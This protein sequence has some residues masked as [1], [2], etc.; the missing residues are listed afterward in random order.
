M[1]DEARSMIHAAKGVIHQA[2]PKY[3]DQLTRPFVTV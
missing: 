3:F 2:F 1:P